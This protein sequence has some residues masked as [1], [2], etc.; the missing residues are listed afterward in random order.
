M[1]LDWLVIDKTKPGMKAS[2]T[3]AETQLNTI[4]NEIKRVST[5]FSDDELLVTLLPGHREKNK[6]INDDLDR[7][8]EEQTKWL[9]ARD[10]CVVTPMET[11]EC[12]RIGTSERADDYAKEQWVNTKEAGF[13]ETY[14][15]IKSYLTEMQ[16]K[17]VPQIVTSPGIAK[18]SG[19]F[20]GS[21]SFRGEEIT[22]IDWLEDAGFEENCCDDRTP[23]ELGKLGSALWRAGIHYAE[24]LEDKHVAQ[25]TLNEIQLV[26]DAAN[27]CQFWSEKGHG[28]KAWF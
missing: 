10:N 7:L 16:G 14:P 21:E 19:E 15:T 23:E 27:W 24:N 3:F 17:W 18:V 4:G 5:K 8:M 11:L 20:T 6:K 2:L 9:E 22:S 12:P 1:G 13:R 25:E 28:V 26:Y